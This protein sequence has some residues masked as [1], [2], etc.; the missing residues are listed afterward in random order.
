MDIFQR[1][2]FARMVSEIALRSIYALNPFFQDYNMGALFNRYFDIVIVQKNLPNL[3]VSGFTILLQVGVG[4]ILVSLY[5]PLFLA[6]NLVVAFLIWLIWVI[7]GRRAIQSAVQ[8]SHQKHAVAAWLQGLATS[9]G[10]F[11]SEKHIAEAFRQTDVFTANYIDRHILHFRHHFAQTVGF[12]ILYAAAS[13]ALLGLGGWLVTQNQLTLGQLV[14][15]ELV[16]SVAFYGVSQLG[17]YLAY[18]Y[19]LCASIDELSLF[20]DIEQEEISGTADHFEGDA[21]LEFVGARG[22]ARGVTTTINLTIPNGARVFGLAESHGV[23]RELA[24]FLKMHA[25]PRGGYITL[26][27]VD[28]RS[29]RAHTIRQEIIVLDRPNAIE[30]TI[31]EY[32]ELSASEKSVHT[33]TEALKIVGLEPAIILLDEGIDTRIAPTGWPLTI[34]E[35]MQLKLAA[36]IIAQPSVLVLNQLFDVMPGASLRRALDVLQQNPD[37]TVIYFSGRERDLGFD[38]YLYLGHEKQQLYPTFTELCRDTGFAPVWA[39]D[40]SRFPAGSRV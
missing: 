6:F 28:I 8:V 21:A 36:A 13:A 22:D 26:G 33:I 34:T 12:L 31:R 19:E 35:T 20:Y 15:A 16:L 17:I 32:L 40:Q 4:F 39:D 27:G 3:L 37:T 10:F 14:A 9:N 25:F 5:H 24:N 23:Q 2:F 30:M 29:V 11:K 38:T 18:F 7:W 1:R